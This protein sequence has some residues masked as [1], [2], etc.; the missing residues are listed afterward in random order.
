MLLD[1]RLATVLRSGAAG[2]AAARTQYRQLLDLLGSTP[3]ETD[4]PLVQAA[5]GRLAEIEERLPPGERSRILREPW[6]R[7]R[8][9]RLLAHLAQGD[10]QAAAAAMATARLGEDE[11]ER[12]IP[13]LPIIA[14]GF[15]RHRRD[16]P[17]GARMLL[18][19]LGVRDLVLPQP[20][21]GS[22]LEL[23]DTM[24]EAAP[25]APEAAPEPAPEP[26]AREDIS[27]LVRRIEAFRQSRAGAPAALAPTL[28]LEGGAPDPGQGA[29]AACD[30]ATDAA[31]RIT[32][33]EGAFAPLL[34]GLVL[35]R[36]GTVDAATGRAMARRQPV[37]G[38]SVDLP[39]TRA[40]A[41]EWRLDAAPRF[42]K[43]TGAFRGYQGRLRRP[44]TATTQPDPGGAGDR[45][46]QVLHELRTPVNA[47]QGFAEIIQQ[48]LF[49]PVPNAYR[50][51]AA[52]IGVDAA[53]LLAGF[54]EIDRMVR[55]EGGA[56][57][58]SPDGSNLR[59]ML[60]RTLRRLEGVMRPRSARMRL[61]TSGDSFAVRLGEE[62]A[63]LLVWR[64]LATLAGSLAPGELVELSLRGGGQ[65]VELVFELPLSLA[66]AGD[67]FAT[68]APSQSA[69]VTAGMFGSG[70]TLRLARAEALAAGGSLDVNGETLVLRLPALTGVGGGHSDGDMAGGSAG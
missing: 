47:V 13:R 34:V 24:V 64:L 43:G 53:K 19:R 55:L 65:V 3:A 66:Q 28:P 10:P 42:A 61:L 39:G 32:W 20:G 16:L 33:A 68:A 63:A 37:R 25:A 48:Q 56:E 11:W 30:F 46:R 29:A 23:D 1:D 4:G 12:L 52:A 44:A 31:G 67:V 21:P 27:A 22:L 35:T 57:D 7:L 59:L 70:F 17:E 51:L 2:E 8:N 60:D 54:D 18:A 45:M 26:D 14:R 6:L 36:P 41:G 5:Y 15:L 9:P 50:A 58:L 49:A 69:A 38:G 62:D 40:V